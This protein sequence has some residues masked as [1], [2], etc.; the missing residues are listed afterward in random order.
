MPSKRSWVAVQNDQARRGVQDSTEK[1]VQTVFKSSF[2][3]D[4]KAIKSK[5][6]LDAVAKLIELV[7]TAQNLR[8]IPDGTLRLTGPKTEQLLNNFLPNTVK[9]GGWSALPIR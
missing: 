8:T 6:L 1:A 5:P 2:A 4:L 7:E 9:N 3:K